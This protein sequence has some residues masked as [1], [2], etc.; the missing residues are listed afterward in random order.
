[1]WSYGSNKD[2]LENRLS[3]I[4]SAASFLF[5]FLQ[6][7]DITGWTSQQIF[8]K[9]GL[10][11]KLFIKDELHPVEKAESGR[12]RIIFSN[13]LIL[14]IVERWTFGRTL[15]DE[16]RDKRYLGQHG[17]MFPTTVGLVMSGPD[18]QLEARAL[19]AKVR[20]SAGDSPASTDASGWDWSVTSQWYMA[21]HCR[22]DGTSPEFQRLTR[23]LFHI[24]MNKCVQL[25]DGTILSQDDPG[26]VPSG[27]YQTGSLNSFIRG[28][29]RWALDR[30]LTTTMGDDCVEAP[31]ED[32]VSRYADYGFTIKF[33]GRLDSFD[34][35]EFC[36][37]HFRN[38]GVVPTK[39][40]VEKMLLKAWTT[41]DIH[42]LDSL[43]LE[44][45]EADEY[46]EVIPHVLGRNEE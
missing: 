42:V 35:F 29:V 32:L 10:C 46:K 28:S 38:G 19:M 21:A 11:Y 13:P 9:L 23:N 27:S 5:F 39:S 31:L 6:E 30:T 44:L 15:D 3:S 16:K 41:N 14:N 34:D 36:S 22:Y 20:G 7:E 26:V 25:S 40:S 17:S 37:K 18:K 4:L 2:A 43:A 1:M 45:S 24:A 33:S 8:K 12:W